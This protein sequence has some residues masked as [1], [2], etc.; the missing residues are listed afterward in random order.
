VKTVSLFSDAEIFMD[1]T[2]MIL[3]QS[4]QRSGDG[5]KVAPPDF[6]VFLCIKARLKRDPF[7]INTSESAFLCSPTPFGQ[8]GVWWS[9]NDNQKKLRMSSEFYS[10]PLKMTTPR[11]RITFIDPTV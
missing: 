6:C 11:N 10:T 1:I 3:A 9:Q 8:F 2:Q 7:T 5:E 4:P